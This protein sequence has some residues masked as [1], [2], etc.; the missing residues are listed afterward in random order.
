MHLKITGQ[1]LLSHAVDEENNQSDAYTYSYT[2]SDGKD[3]ARVI[4]GREAALISLLIQ[5]RKLKSTQDSAES[6][7]A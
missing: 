5:G 3:Y 2:G 7:E 4:T 6:F 1:G